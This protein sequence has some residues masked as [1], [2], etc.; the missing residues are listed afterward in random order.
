MIVFNKSPVSFVNLNNKRYFTDN[1]IRPQQ[2]PLFTKIIEN[3]EQFP[4]CQ[5]G[6][7]PL[8]YGIDNR[9]LPSVGSTIPV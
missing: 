9:L 7:I 1:R 2:K 5:F 6:D 8:N 4:M 3:L